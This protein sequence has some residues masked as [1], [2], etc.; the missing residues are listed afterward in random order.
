MKRFTSGLSQIRKTKLR[1]SFQDNINSLS[2]CKNDVEPT[3]H[4]LLQCREFINERR[5][6]LST[7]VNLITNL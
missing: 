2:S 5:T 4:L 1:H 6:L 3:E 7:I